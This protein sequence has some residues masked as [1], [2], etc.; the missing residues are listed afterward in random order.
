MAYAMDELPEQTAVRLTAEDLGLTNLQQE[1][2]EALD[3]AY[4]WHRNLVVGESAH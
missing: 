3:G 4:A 2:E 1:D